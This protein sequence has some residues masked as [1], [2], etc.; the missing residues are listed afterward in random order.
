MGTVGECEGEAWRRELGSAGGL[1]SH[2]SDDCIARRDWMDS[3][4]GV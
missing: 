4:Y 2:V 1:T 3:D